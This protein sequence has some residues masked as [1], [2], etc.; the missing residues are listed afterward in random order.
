[1]PQ[2]ALRALRDL[3]ERSTP[4]S[5]V[6][7]EHARPSLWQRIIGNVPPDRIRALPLCSTGDTDAGAVVDI[8]GI[9]ADGDL[10]VVHDPETNENTVHLWHPAIPVPPS[11]TPLGIGLATLTVH[12]ASTR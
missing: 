9:P 5:A 3:C 12:R 10:V 2:A 1:M 8:G 6:H 4:I 7:V 11:L